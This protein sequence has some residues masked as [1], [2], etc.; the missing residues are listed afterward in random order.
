MEEALTCRLA[1]VGDIYDRSE[2]ETIMREWFD[3]DEDGAIEWAMKLPEGK[4]K[5]QLLG[6]VVGIWGTSKPDKAKNWIEQS[7]LSQDK[8]DKLLKKIEKNI[9]K[10]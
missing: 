3:Y 1:K 7:S 5:D 6:A 4:N 8:K 9:P 10:K 2:L